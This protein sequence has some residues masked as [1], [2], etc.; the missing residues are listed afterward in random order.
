MAT[1]EMNL[2]GQRD[3]VNLKIGGILL[4]AGAALFLLAD[5]VLGDSEAA[6]YAIV[7]GMILFPVGVILTLVGLI[8]IAFAKIK[9]RVKRK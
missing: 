3:M 7:L 9:E 2:N 6:S 5:T 8:Q 4:V 1:L